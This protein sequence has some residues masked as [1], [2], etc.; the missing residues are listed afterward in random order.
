M[1]RGNLL[2]LAK[3]HCSLTSGGI[4]Q[5]VERLEKQDGRDIQIVD[6]KTPTRGKE[7]TILEQLIGNIG[8]FSGSAGEDGAGG[9]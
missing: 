3:L 8:K 2:N 5:Q 4:V 7:L 9:P 1:H 6:R